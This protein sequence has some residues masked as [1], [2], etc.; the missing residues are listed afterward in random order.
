MKYSL[1]FNKG[2]KKSTFSITTS[3]QPRTAHPSYCN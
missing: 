3:T 2:N 1:P